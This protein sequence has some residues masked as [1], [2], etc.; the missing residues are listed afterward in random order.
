M[1]VLVTGSE[2][3]IGTVLTELLR[4]SGH[5]VTGL[6]T[7]F[8]TR[9]L[10]GP[11]P[12]EAPARRTDVRDVESSDCA[13]FDAVLHLAALCNDPLGDLNPAL[14]GDINYRATMRL[15]AAAKAAGVKRFVFSSSCSVYGAGIDDEPLTEDSPLAPITPYAESKIRS[16]K[17]LLELANDDFSPVILRNSTAYGFSPRLRGDLVVNDL[18]AHALLIGEVRL[19]SDGTA[20]RPLVHVRDIAQAFVAMLELACERVHGKVY[21]VGGSTENYL[22]RTVAQIVSDAVPGSRITFADKPSADKRNYRVSCDR[23]AA[24]VPE[25]RPQWNLLSGITQLTDAYRRYGLTLADF[26]GE[27]HQRLLR[28]KALSAN[29]R[30][31]SELRWTG[32]WQEAPSELD[33]ADLEGATT[34]RSA[35]SLS[36]RQRLGVAG[37]PGGTDRGHMR[38]R[39]RRPAA[40]HDRR[41]RP[42]VSQARAHGRPGALPL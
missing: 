23:I 41:P 39:S 24:E 31:D 9:C 11:A 13:G 36:R 29:G 37:G 4:E 10:L 12:A 7:G 25:F 5:D 20:W 40:A 1:R 6:D 26:I 2:G 28:I 19:M 30:L 17:A 3:Y 32:G 16:E 34:L 22:I 42:G 8:F 14:T 18:V 35:K 33:A 21:N 27:R 38:A 15:A